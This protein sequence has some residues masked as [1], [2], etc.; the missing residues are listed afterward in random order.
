MNRH[1]GRLFGHEIDLRS[2][3]RGEL[4]FC[5]FFDGL[6]RIELDGLAFHGLFSLNWLQ[7]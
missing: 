5:G 2:L 7:Q 1:F 6:V 3:F 4:D